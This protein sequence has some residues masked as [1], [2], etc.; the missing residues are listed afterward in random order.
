MVDTPVDYAE[1]FRCGKQAKVAN[2]CGRVLRGMQPEDFATLTNDPARRIVL[3]MGPDG[4]ETLPGHS[5]YEILKI[6]GYTSGYIES[7][8]AE[9]VQFKLVIF[10]QANN[11]RLATWDNVLGMASDVYPEVAEMLASCAA[12]LKRLSFQEIESMA[13]F[14]FADVDMAGHDDPRYMT[15]DRYLKSKG[16]VVSTRAFLY[17]TLYLREQFVGDGYTEDEYG[18]RGIREYIIPNQTLHELRPHVL[19]DLPV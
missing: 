1:A 15:L 18:V 5:G 4:L 10:P 7:K 17:F 19:L 13:G 11:A 16:G 9:G 3:L 8:I 6:I 2:L 14:S 12:E